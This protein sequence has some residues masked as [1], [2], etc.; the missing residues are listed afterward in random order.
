MP[1]V[2]S[3]STNYNVRLWNPSILPS[4]SLGAGSDLQCE[5]QTAPVRIALASIL[6]II[7]NFRLR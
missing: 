1:D 5:D 2:R 6:T 4:F 7:S 3:L